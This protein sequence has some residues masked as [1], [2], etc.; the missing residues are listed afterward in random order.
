MFPAMLKI[1]EQLFFNYFQ[2][3]FGLLLFVIA[4]AIEIAESVAVFCRPADKPFVFQVVR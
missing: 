3:F 1:R 4:K 2:S